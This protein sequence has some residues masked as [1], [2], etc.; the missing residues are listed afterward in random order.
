MRLRLTIGAA[1]VLLGLF[2]LFRLLTQIPAGDLVMLFVWL[3]GA[4]VI[5]DGIL[6][7]AVVAVGAAVAQLPVRARRYLQGALV[8]GALVTVIA[9]PLIHREN[10]QPGVKA[11]LRQDYAA[12]LG[13]LLGLIGAGALALYALRV[14]RDRQ[15]PSTTNERPADDQV[16]TTRKPA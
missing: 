7:P 4:L 13:L 10:T 6:S 16:S 2:G 8:S 9:L 12:H 15:R 11:L 5:H 1:G 3:V 14:V